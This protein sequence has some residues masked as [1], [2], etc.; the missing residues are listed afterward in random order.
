LILRS[1]PQVKY[2]G[3]DDFFAKRKYIDEVL[4]LELHPITELRRDIKP[5]PLMIKTQIKENRAWLDRCFLDLSIMRLAEAL[6]FRGV[7]R[8]ATPNCL[9]QGPLLFESVGGSD[10][11]N[12]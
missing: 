11:A 9:K 1:P 3:S 2:H 7:G 10:C 6:I 12:H 8:R 4:V 5:P